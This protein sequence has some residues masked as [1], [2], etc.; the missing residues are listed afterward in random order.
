MALLSK[1]DIAKKTA[2]GLPR[3]TVE[4][5]EWGGEVLV[6]GM[7][8]RQR[9]RFEAGLLERR[10][11]HDVTNVDNIRTKVV[12]QCLIGEDGERLYAD[13][14]A[15]ELGETAGAAAIERIYKV[16]ARLSGISDDD[17]EE[18]AGTIAADPS[19]GSPSSSPGPSAARHATSS[20]D[21]ST[22]TP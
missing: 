22:P 17:L 18:L 20:S 12:V 7:T 19:T 6:Q 21:G 8:G 3:E 2:E 11:R 14:E 1:E 10:G 16:A 15:D 13:H 9:D 4:V 5:P